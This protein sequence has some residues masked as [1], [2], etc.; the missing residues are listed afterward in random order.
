MRLSL[1]PPITPYLHPHSFLGNSPQLPSVSS[2][3]H[4]PPLHR[5]K[6][7]TSFP[8]PAGMSLTKLPLVRNNSVMTSL[9]PPRASLV[10]TSRVG[11][12]NSRIFFLWCTLQVFIPLASSLFSLHP[13]FLVFSFS[14]LL[15][16]ASILRSSTSSL[17]S[18][19]SILLLSASNLHSQLSIRINAKES[20]P[21]GYSG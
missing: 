15:S 14:V 19:S 12:G 11:T 2:I 18:S 4:Q 1:K 3:T 13:L 8:S 5:K 17:F 20:I 16:S 9:F 7:F 21:P 6:R 10:V